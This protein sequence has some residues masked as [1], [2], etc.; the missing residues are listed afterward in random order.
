MAIFLFVYA[1]WV[2]IR[3]L[4]AGRT[5][6]IIAHRLST[7]INAD[8]ILVLSAGSIVESGTH[9]ELLIKGGIYRGFYIRQFKSA[10]NVGQ[11]LGNFI[12]YLFFA[13]PNAPVRFYRITQPAVL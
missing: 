13:Y 7:V 5:T 2:Y 4:V 1:T 3:H 8:R 9:A 10:K 12:Q 11:L 6:F